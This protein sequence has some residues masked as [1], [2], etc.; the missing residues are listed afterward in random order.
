M[1]KCA[2]NF[3][4]GPCGGFVNGKCEV[5]KDRNC[6]WVL[7]YQTIKDNKKQLENFINSYIEPIIQKNL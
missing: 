7:I 3:H 5:Y 1:S 2:K 6:V 4:N